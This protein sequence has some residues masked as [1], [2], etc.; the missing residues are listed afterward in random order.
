MVLQISV[1]NDVDD[2]CWLEIWSI[3]E[4]GILA[5]QGSHSAECK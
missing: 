5:N 1:G 2:F 3:I 4:F